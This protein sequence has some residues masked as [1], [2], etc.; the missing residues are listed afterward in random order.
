MGEW[1]GVVGDQFYMAQR[2]RRQRSWVKRLLVYLFVPLGV[3]L[4]AFVIWFYW[5][6][7]RELWD[8]EQ[9]MKGR[10][11]NAARQVDKSERAGRGPVKRP[12]EKIFDEERKNLDDIIKRKQ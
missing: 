12:P 8:K 10:P 3:W 2:R 6:D 9:E 7:I 1:G 11:P 5:Y 4:V